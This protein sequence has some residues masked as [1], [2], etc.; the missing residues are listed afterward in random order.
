M[1]LLQNYTHSPPSR[2]TAHVRRDWRRTLGAALPIAPSIPLGKFFLLSDHLGR[3][4]RCTHWFLS[5]ERSVL[6]KLRPH[7]LPGQVSAD[8]ESLPQGTRGSLQGEALSPT[9]ETTHPLIPG[10]ALPR[11]SR[12]IPSPSL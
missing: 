8:S 9:P 1:I 12:V 3:D 7:P 2:W 10:P 6:L 11:A 4:N 5:G